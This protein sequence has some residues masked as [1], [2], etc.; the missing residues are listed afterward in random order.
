MLK[1]GLIS[2]W[3]KKQ[4]TKIYLPANKHTG[5]DL[6]LSTHTNLPGKNCYFVGCN[7]SMRQRDIGISK[8]HSARYVAKKW[9]DEGC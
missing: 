7:V 9:I 1:T 5:S 6:N 4:N 8:M 3:K 2:C